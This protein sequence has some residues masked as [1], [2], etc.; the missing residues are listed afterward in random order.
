MRTLYILFLVALATFLMAADCSNKDS[1]FYNDVFVS[2][3]NLVTIARSVIPE[4]QTVFVIA[5]VNRF[6][7]ITGQNNLLDIY[8]TTGGAVKLNFSYELEKQNN[9]NWDDV[10]LSDNQLQIVKG[11]AVSGE[12]VDAFCVYNTANQTY[13]SE[14]GI[15]S[16]PAGNYRLSFG[17]NSDAITDIDFRSLSFNSNLFLNLKSS[18]VALNNQGFYL[19]TIQ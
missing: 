19:F 7:S 11:E 2:A 15:T 16:L 13:E 12:F 3:P 14:V 6:L 17:F 4:E 18:S 5:S 9:T 1:E 8:K 10:T